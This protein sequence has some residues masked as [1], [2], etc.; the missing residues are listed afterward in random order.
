MADL[1]HLGWSNGGV[2]K[3]VDLKLNSCYRIVGALGGVDACGK[4]A[5][6]RRHREVD[7]IVFFINKNASIINAIY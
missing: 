5:S 1:V 4:R 7:G 2:Y 3:C 6:G